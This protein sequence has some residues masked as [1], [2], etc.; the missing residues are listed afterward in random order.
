MVLQCLTH[1]G[2]M[3]LSLTVKWYFILPHLVC[4]VNWISRTKMRHITKQRRKRTEHTLKLT[5]K[6]SQIFKLQES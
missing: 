6:T 3:S 2:C 5:L 4:N 1:S